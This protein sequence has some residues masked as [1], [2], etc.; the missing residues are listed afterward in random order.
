M[1]GA[2]G[3]SRATVRKMVNGCAAPAPIPADTGFGANGPFDITVRG[4]NIRGDTTLVIVPVGTPTSEITNNG[5]TVVPSAKDVLGSVVTAIT[6]ANG[7]NGDV[8]EM[9]LIG[10][11]GTRVYVGNITF[12]FP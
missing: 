11:C 4:L 2:G 7:T 3:T 12:S 9:F 10:P 8:F 6:L 5:K 1:R